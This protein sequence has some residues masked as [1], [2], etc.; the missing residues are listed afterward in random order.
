M[1]LFPTL[2]LLATTRSFRY[3]LFPHFLS[4]NDSGCDEDRGAQ[5]APLGV[6]VLG[7]VEC[8]L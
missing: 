1:A 5:G 7:R 4:E 2:A 6:C 3:R 8:T